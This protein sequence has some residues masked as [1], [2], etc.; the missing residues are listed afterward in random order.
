M[1]W[2]WDIF[3]A[4]TRNT[5][6]ILLGIFEEKRTLGKHRRRW[7]DNIAVDVRSIECVDGE[8]YSPVSRQR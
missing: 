2:K 4:E 3:I 6:R 1:S 8:L 7:K 5:C